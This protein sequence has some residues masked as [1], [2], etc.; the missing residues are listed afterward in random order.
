MPGIQ[1]GS[2]PGCVFFR[3]TTSALTF[4]LGV[5]VQEGTEGPKVLCRKK[6][7]SYAV[8]CLACREYSKPTCCASANAVTQATPLCMP[9]SPPPPPSPAAPPFC[10]EAVTLTDALGNAKTFKKT[11]SLQSGRPIYSVDGDLPFSSG[12]DGPPNYLFYS[13]SNKVWYVGGDYIGGAYQS[14]TETALKPAMKSATTTGTC[15]DEAASWSTVSTSGLRWQAPVLAVPAYESPPPPPA[16]PPPPP[17][18]PPPSPPPSPPPP[19]PPATRRRQLT[20]EPVWLTEH[21]DKRCQH[22]DT[23]RLQYDDPLTTDTKKFVGK[24]PIAHPSLADRGNAGE[25]LYFS[26]YMGSPPS[27]EKLYQD[28]VASWYGEI[29]DYDFVS[30]PAVGCK[31]DSSKATGHFTQVVWKATSKVGCAVFTGC[32]GK[33]M[34]QWAAQ[35]DMAVVACR[36]KDMGN[37]GGASEYPANVGNLIASSSCSSGCT[38]QS[39]PPPAPPAPPPSPIPPYV[40][41]P[42]AAPEPTFVEIHNDYRCKQCATGLV[43]EDESLTAQ[44]QAFVNGCPTG[45]PPFSERDGAGENIYFSGYMGADPTD[46]EVLYNKAL[47]SWYGEIENYDFESCSSV[48]C[49][50]TPVAVTGHFTQVR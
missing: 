41:P 4:G 50:K 28:A 32:E 1:V 19:S 17:P 30:C 37:F 36:Y 14:A 7:W 24:C 10:C 29:D 3:S 31:K 12:A 47:K 45:H 26:F 48:G 9:L 22:C 8:G 49:K 16:P 44:T 18:P 39:P 5:G 13:P 27:D 40:S 43:A 11:L 15:P 42:A 25:N 21:N 38:A 35:Y 34:G 23:A 46:Y 33:L 20:T 6:D 2:S